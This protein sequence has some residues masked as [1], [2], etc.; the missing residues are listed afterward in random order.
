MSIAELGRLAEALVSKDLTQ[1]GYTI[2]A[3]NYRKPWGEIDVI[4]K[5]DDIIIFIEVKASRQLLSGFEPELRADRKKIKRV[6]RTAQTYLLEKRYPTEQ[7][8]QIDVIAVTVNDKGE[9]TTL[10]HFQNI[11][12]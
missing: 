8:W 10:N 6:I 1:K 11:D 12:V 3:H 7:P 5:K 2:L 4:A 9:I